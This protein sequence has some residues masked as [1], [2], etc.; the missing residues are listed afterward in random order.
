LGATQG[1][2]YLTPFGVENLDEIKNPEGDS[3]SVATG[4]TR[5]RNAW[6]YPHEKGL[7]FSPDLKTNLLK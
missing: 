1:N 2:Q 3:I 6:M 4:E 5:G 7:G